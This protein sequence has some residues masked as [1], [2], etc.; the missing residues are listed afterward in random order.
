MCGRAKSKDFGPPR[1]SQLAGVASMVFRIR[2][3][4][5]LMGV[6][7]GMLYFVGYLLIFRIFKMNL[8]W[9]ETVPKGAVSRGKMVKS[10]SDTQPVGSLEVTLA[11]PG[12]WPLDFARSLRIYDQNIG[13]TF[14]INK[15]RSSVEFE[16]FLI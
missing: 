15:G 6:F 10:L 9:F 5:G 13:Y 2:V 3:W 7:W 12:G 1:R 14:R 8:K 16:F 11:I 4:S